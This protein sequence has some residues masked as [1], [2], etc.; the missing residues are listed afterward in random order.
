[1]TPGLLSCS[2]LVDA[3]E[4][5]EL[6]QDQTSPSVA[7][8]SQNDPKRTSS[9]SMSSVVGFAAPLSTLPFTLT[10]T[11]NRPA[12]PRR[13]IEITAGSNRD[14]EVRPRRRFGDRR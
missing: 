11:Q 9:L 6:P 7:L 4:C 2:N 5:L 8:M 1:M 12:S 10:L 14:Y 3:V 13:R